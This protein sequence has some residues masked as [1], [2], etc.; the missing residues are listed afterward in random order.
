MQDA[1]VLDSVVLSSC[2]AVMRELRKTTEDAGLCPVG[3]GGT[4]LYYC[5]NYL[6]AQHCDRDL[7]WSL[8]CQLKKVTRDIRDYSFAY[9]RW[10]V[11]VETR[12]RAVWYVNLWFYFKVLI[13]VVIFANNRWFRSEDHH[14]TVMPPNSALASHSTHAAAAAY[15]V[16]KSAGLHKTVKKKDARKAAHY[17]NVRAGQ[18]AVASYWR[19]EGISF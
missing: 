16:P 6:A 9:S 2:P 1:D 13:L 19:E 3:T 12:S 8:C 14:G 17:R 4:N 11:Y 7:S 15:P 18:K 5:D 10:G